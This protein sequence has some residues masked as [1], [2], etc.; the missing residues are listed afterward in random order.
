HARRARP[1]LR[2]R[3]Q[4]LAEGLQARR[5][6]ARRRHVRGDRRHDRR[7]P[8]RRALLPRRSDG[9]LSRHA[10]R[11]ADR[12]LATNHA[13]LGLQAGLLIA[14]AVARG[15]WG[16]YDPTVAGATK[17]MRQKW[18]RASS[19][20]APSLVHERDCASSGRAAAGITYRRSSDISLRLP[21]Q[22]VEQS[23]ELI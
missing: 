14:R 23:T 6:G 10:L 20:G 19:T 13:S 1:L 12:A 21:Y 7:L 9:E 5:L 3:H 17:T 16:P 8:G 2:R 18:S 15:A 22:S 11:D 4:R